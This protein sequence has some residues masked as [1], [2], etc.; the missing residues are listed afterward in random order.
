[1]LGKRP[2]INERFERAVIDTL[3]G[4]VRRNKKCSKGPLLFLGWGVLPPHGHNWVGPRT[5]INN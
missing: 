4:G 1:M 2:V 5:N 3:Q